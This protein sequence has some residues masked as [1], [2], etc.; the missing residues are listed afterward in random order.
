MSETL[1]TKFD[2]AIGA[3]TGLPDVIHTSPATVDR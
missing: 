3:L 2:R 1:A